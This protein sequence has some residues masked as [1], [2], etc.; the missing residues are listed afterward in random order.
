MAPCTIRRTCWCRA[1][2]IADACMYDQDDSQSAQTKATSDGSALS[3]DGCSL[4]K[5]AAW[6][7]P[8]CKDNT[9]Y[10]YLTFKGT[11]EALEDH[12]AKLTTDFSFASDVLFCDDEDNT[13]VK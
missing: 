2:I 8:P 9:Q 13:C 10:H 7:D 11:T 4:H 6:T 12:N 5:L 3:V 1:S